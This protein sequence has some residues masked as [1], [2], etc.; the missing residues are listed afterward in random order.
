MTIHS[1]IVFDVQPRPDCN[2]LC[3]D[4]VIALFVIRE[5]FAKAAKE[6]CKD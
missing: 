2:D 6:M 5:N 3:L 4:D 1:S